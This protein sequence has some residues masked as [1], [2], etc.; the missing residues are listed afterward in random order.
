VRSHRTLR[1]GIGLVLLFACLGFEWEGRLAR[2]QRELETADAG[3]RREVVRLL[4]AY[5]A[6][7][8]EGALLEALSDD[9]AG[10]RAEAAAAAARVGLESAVPRLLDWLD[11][12]NADLRASAARALGRIG[13][14]R[15]VPPLIRALG[16]SSSDVRK[17][18]ME[19]L[20]A[21]GTPNVIVPILGRLDD[22]DVS[23]R[24]AAA[25]ALGELGDPRAVVPLV[26]RSRDDA[27]EVRVSVYRALGALEDGRAVPALLQGLRQSAEEIRFA[28]ITALGQLGSPAALEPLAE[29]ARQGES[30]TARAAIAAIAAI[31]GPEATDLLIEALSRNATRPTAQQLLALSA[32]RPRAEGGGITRERMVERLERSLE[33]TT[34]AEQATAIA[35]IM[36]ELARSEPA[37][38]LAPALL[39]A[40]REGRGRRGALMKALAVTGSPDALVPLL[41]GLEHEDDEVQSAALRG[42]SA[43]FERMGPDGRAA[44]PLLEALGRV[45]EGLRTDVV[46]LLGE[47]GATRALPSI[48]PLLRH[49]SPTLRRAAVEALGSIGDSSAVPALMELLDDRHARTRFEAAQALAS[50]ATPATAEDLLGRLTSDEPAD[51]HALLIALGG[52]LA[53]FDGDELSVALRDRSRA[54]LVT[55]VAG[56]DRRLAARAIDTMARW[57]HPSLVPALLDLEPGLVPPVRR[58]LVGALRAFDDPKAVT[59]L[60][61][62]AEHGERAVRVAAAGALGERSTAERVALLLSLAQTASWPV[63]AA[64]S[65][66]LARMARRGVIAEAGP[67]GEAL[68][69]LAASRSPYV[70]AN[71]AAALAALAVPRCPGGE[72]DP[73][74]WL[75]PRHAPAVRVA[76]VRWL[77]S[78]PAS[79]PERQKTIDEALEHCIHADLASEV[80][81]ACRDPSLPPLDAEADVYTYEADGDALLADRLVAL[82]LTDGTVLLTRSDPNGHVRLEPAP[83]GAL[84][85]DDPVSTPLEP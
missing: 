52:A 28:S 79:T 72:P 38:S 20:R 57:G 27:Q 77:A 60:A 74:T 85:L 64:A 75:G 14:D 62:L 44:D 3:R 81:G 41:E 50:V 37:P 51:R 69:E 23:V 49:E 67:H 19:G 80:V 31:G 33:R 39:R 45:G 24:A 11:D 4:G 40:L 46:R 56:P 82:R 73:L 12:P 65:F 9:D 61:A 83:S 25:E 48:R 16:D 8:V 71:A 18:A 43:Y 26:G 21:I 32:R 29:L 34:H 35:E 53:R 2:L 70:R 10:V 63:P 66:S 42:L 5:P 7:E 54:A 22:P 30:R 13:L 76:A 17:A 6:A 47:V 15:T 68:C 55:L 58:A 1:V 59:R 78:A 36:H 84:I